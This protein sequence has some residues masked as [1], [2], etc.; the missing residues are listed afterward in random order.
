MP[1]HCGCFGSEGRASYGIWGVE[2]RESSFTFLHTV[3]LILITPPPDTGLDFTH[4]PTLTSLTLDSIPNIQNFGSLPI[5]IRTPH[6]LRHLDLSNIE[7]AEPGTSILGGIDLASLDSLALWEVPLTHGDM[8]SIFAPQFSDGTM[9]F[10]QPTP[11]PCMLKRLEM[12]HVNPSLLAA[13]L[14]SSHPFPTLLHLRFNI[15]NEAL[16]DSLPSFLGRANVLQE[17]ELDGFRHVLYQPRV[18]DDELKAFSKFTQLQTL[19]IRYSTGGMDHMVPF[20]DTEVE[21]LSAMFRSFATSFSSTKHR[22][23]DTRLQGNFNG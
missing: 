9:P 18:I 21:K 12:T 13:T 17:L 22:S 19:S 2:T 23:S 4:I 14:R 7:P 20:T 5:C 6:T 1:C 8:D 3:S 16:L 11:R 10:A 15:G